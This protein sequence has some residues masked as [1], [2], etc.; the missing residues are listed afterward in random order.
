MEEEPKELMFPYGKC[1]EARIQ[2][3]GRNYNESN[4][5]DFVSVL[6]ANGYKV[7]IERPTQDFYRIQYGH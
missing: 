7:V 1:G 5:C 6:I 3:F 2:S 4:V